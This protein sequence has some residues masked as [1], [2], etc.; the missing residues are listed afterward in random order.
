MIVAPSDCNRVFA[1]DAATGLLLWYG[2]ARTGSD[3][4]WV[5]AVET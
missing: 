4:C 5:W 3:T 1:L 2:E